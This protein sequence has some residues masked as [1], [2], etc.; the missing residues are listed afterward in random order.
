MGI[1]PQL[2]KIFQLGVR[3][4]ASDSV[5]VAGVFAEVLYLIRHRTNKR[6]PTY[7]SLDWENVFPFFF[8]FSSNASRIFSGV[9]GSSMK[10]TPMAS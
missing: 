9:N 7:F 5:S 4:S 10:L 6:L 8:L 2:S 3:G 1:S